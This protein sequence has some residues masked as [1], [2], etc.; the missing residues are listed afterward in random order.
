MIFSSLGV[1][2]GSGL[3][4]VF[5]SIYVDPGVSSSLTVD[6]ERWVGAWW[7][8][9]AIFSAVAVFW[10]LGIM[11]F[12][13]QLPGTK[14]IREAAENDGNENLVRVSVVFCKTKKIP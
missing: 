4:S 2:V 6:D 14:A 1:L 9:F 5:L 7:L 12:P 10:G 13:R 3:S 8:G 11:G